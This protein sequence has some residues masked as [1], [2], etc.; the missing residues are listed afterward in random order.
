MMARAWPG[1]AALTLAVSALACAGARGI[2]RPGSAPSATSPA[3][4]AAELGCASSRAS[5]SVLA[6]LS[7]PRT[8]S[9]VALAASA[10]KVFAYIADEDDWAV[11]VVDLEPRNKRERK[12]LDGPPTE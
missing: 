11:H 5:T 12:A 3:P 6:P 8:G 1:L 4:V 7:M 10:G 2:A 9:T